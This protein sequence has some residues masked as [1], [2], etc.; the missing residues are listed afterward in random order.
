MLNQSKG[1]LEQ[2]HWS[3]DVIKEERDLLKLNQDR[4]DAKYWALKKHADDLEIQSTTL[5]WDKVKLQGQLQVH[6]KEI[7]K[8]KEK[9]QVIVHKKDEVN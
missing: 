3:Y 2:K 1:N 5:Q 6:E 4:E 8:L 7:F 9:I